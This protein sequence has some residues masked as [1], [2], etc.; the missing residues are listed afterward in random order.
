MA[1]KQ[2]TLKIKKKSFHHCQ[3]AIFDVKIENVALDLYIYFVYLCILKSLRIG[4]CFPKG[5]TLFY[6]LCIKRSCVFI[7]LLSVDWKDVQPSFLTKLFFPLPVTW[8]MMI[9][10][11][12]HLFLSFLRVSCFKAF[13]SWR[14]EKKRLHSKH[15]CTVWL[16]REQVLKKKKYTYFWFFVSMLSPGYPP[17]YMA[18]GVK[19]VI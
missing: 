8:T 3:Q 16:P 12:E 2:F 9:F 17:L 6:I 4:C 18:V 7:F 19:I 5:L 10:T 1:W 15:C 13:K 14:K 11:N